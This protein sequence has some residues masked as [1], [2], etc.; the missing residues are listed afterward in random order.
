MAMNGNQLG[1]EIAN[2]I[3]NLSAPDDV[4][5]QVLDLW[6]RIATCIVDHITTNG[7]VPSGIPVSTPSGQG[8]TSG[9]G[10][11]I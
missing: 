10:S 1:Q 8:A 3:M 2:A 4:K 7:I 6:Q 9:P 5:A 11:I